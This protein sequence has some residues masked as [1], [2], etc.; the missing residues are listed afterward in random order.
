M[1]KYTEHHDDN[2]FEIDIDNNKNAINELLGNQSQFLD[3][4]VVNILKMLRD[5]KQNRQKLFRDEYDALSF[6]AYYFQQ[7]ASNLKSI[8]D[9]RFLYQ[10]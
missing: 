7:I 3:P 5:K 10:K 2:M 9:Q 1:K 8:L 4:E 6:D